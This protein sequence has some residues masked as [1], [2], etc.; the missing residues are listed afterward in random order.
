MLINDIE[1]RL[2]RPS[3]DV[4]GL[5][6]AQ[7][8]ERLAARSE[9]LFHA[10][11]LER[12]L[13]LGRPLKV[14]FGIDPTGTQVHI[15]HAVVYRKLRQFQRL[16]HTVQVLIGNF[17]AMI[18]DTSD[19]LAMRVPLTK[20]QVDANMQTYLAQ[21]GKIIDLDAAEHFRNGD[22]FFPMKLETFLP[23]LSTLTVSQLLER[24]NFKLRYEK[25][26]PIGVHEL[27]YPLLQGY[28]SVAMRSDV[29]LGG[30]DQLFNMLRGRDLQPLHEQEPQVVLTM[31]LLVGTDG[32]K[33][34]KSYGNTIAL[35]DAPEDAYGK[36][37]SVA[38]AHLRQYALLLTD[39][40]DGEW[41][42]LED[43]M[44]LGLNPKEVK[45][46]L[47]RLI[48]GD[49][50]G[51]DAALAAEAQWVNQFSEGGVPENIPTL[52]VIHTEITIDS[53]A[54]KIIG[55][56]FVKTKSEL[57]RLCDQGGVRLISS[58]EEIGE[59]KVA[60]AE[61]FS[62]SEGDTLKIGKRNFIRFGKA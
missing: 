51:R 34:S 7:Q 50:H 24:E 61:K 60:Y 39:M 26:T 33:M 25:G 46:L 38:D 37:M 35:T 43:A 28:D 15:G 13:A 5:P 31:P 9:H 30:T 10:D 8:F 52:Q 54:E 44:R 55:F 20:E 36:L 4:P 17:T 11:D 40:E 23:L 2:N 47:A 45:M 58:N 57:R 49:L 56:G 22:W 6:A 59:T 48:V 27:T 3:P 29:E 41:Q 21:V 19:K 12:K 32:R 18:G 62:I 1:S 14:K 42:Q 16:G 53:V